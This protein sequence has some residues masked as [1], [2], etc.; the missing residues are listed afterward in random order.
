MNVWLTPAVQTHPLANFL[1]SV[2]RAWPSIIRLGMYA[3]LHD[4]AASNLEMHDAPVQV[5]LKQ[6]VREKAGSP[7][8]FLV[9]EQ[10]SLLCK[11][12]WCD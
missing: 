7:G 2:W 10:Q 5:S 4:I 3:C 1:M 8:L 12:F 11:P 6:S 9:N